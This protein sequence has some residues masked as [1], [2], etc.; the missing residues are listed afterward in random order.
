MKQR[1]GKILILIAAAV[2]VLSGCGTNKKPSE[3]SLPTEVPAKNMVSEQT[4]ISATPQVTEEPTLTPRDTREIV[5]YTLNS[6]SLEKE[7]ITALV[8][9]ESK[10]TPELI[11]E[12]VLDAMEDD[13]YYIKIDSMSTKDKNIIVSF[14][15]DSIPVCDVGS[16]VES[17]ILDAIGQSLLDNL[18]EYN[19][20]IYRIEGKAY[21]SGHI[22]IGID[23]V[24]ISR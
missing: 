13:F 1:Q 24:F 22:E 7:A 20:V 5:I 19:G 21:E 23:E 15:A 9:T 8:Y 11:M 6:E 17:T 3:N 16:G 2:C 18:P 14:C 12:Q 4:V 10:L